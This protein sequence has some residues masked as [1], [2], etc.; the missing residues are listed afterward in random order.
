MF[1]ITTEL[2]GA[3]VPAGHTVQGYTTSH[4]LVD[5]IL[6]KKHEFILIKY[7]NLF[8]T[9]RTVSENKHVSVLHTS[10]N[11]WASQLKL[12]VRWELNFYKILHI[13]VQK[14][15]FLDR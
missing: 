8:Q 13:F 14:T 11:E 5:F 12:E 9:P 10:S 15:L 7:L 4:E 2:G 3:G 1:R 6:R